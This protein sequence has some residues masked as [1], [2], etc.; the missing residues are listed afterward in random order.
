MQLVWFVAQ[1]TDMVKE[2]LALWFVS[3][4]FSF[5]L[6]CEGQSLCWWYRSVRQGEMV[7]GCKMC[8]CLSTVPGSNGLRHQLWGEGGRAGREAQKMHVSFVLGFGCVRRG[9]GNVWNLYTKW[10]SQ[11]VPYLAWRGQ[12][13]WWGSVWN[14]QLLLSM[15]WV[16]QIL[17]LPRSWCFIQSEVQFFHSQLVN[18]KGM[19]SPKELRN[20]KESQQ[21]W[22]LS[23]M[24]VTA[25]ETLMT[26]PLFKGH[27]QM[28]KLSPDCCALL[29]SRA[30]LYNELSL[31]PGKFE[32]RSW[33]DLNI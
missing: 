15:Y 26:R 25:I 9:H 14:G 24:A 32:A 29:Y 30:I 1:A 23:Q 17:Q 2:L 11:Q 12:K 27:F 4:S 28:G 33:L 7:L 31:S 5:T 20:S 10:S 19:W 13:G 18:I 21:T 22:K 16:C 6:P 8:K 3:F